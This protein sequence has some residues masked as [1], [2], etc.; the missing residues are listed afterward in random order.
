LKEKY[1]VYTL[2][3]LKDLKLY[4]GFS[5]DLQKR[6]VEH[7]KG[8]VSSTRIRK[9]FLLIHYEYFIDKQDAKSRERFLKSGFGRKQLKKSLKRTLMGRGVRDVSS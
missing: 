5:V 4:T 8:L 3:S 7:L 2:L 1:Y 9:P 6:L